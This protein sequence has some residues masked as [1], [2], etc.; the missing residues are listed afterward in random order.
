MAGLA[1]SVEKDG[2][3]AARFYNH[4]RAFLIDLC[5]MPSAVEAFPVN[6]FKAITSAEVKNMEVSII[7]SKE[8]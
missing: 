4:L 6:P 2:A 7:S 3:Y 5:A 8:V 1:R